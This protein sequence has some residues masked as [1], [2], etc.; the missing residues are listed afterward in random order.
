MAQLFPHRGSIRRCYVP[1]DEI[2]RVR[3]SLI[4]RIK[5]EAPPDTA[6]Q[7]NEEKCNTWRILREFSRCEKPHGTDCQIIMHFLHKDRE[8][9]VRNDANV[10]I[11]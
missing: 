8:T 5:P 2:P 6:V 11:A 9:T 4:P 10:R 3:H 7:R 1:P